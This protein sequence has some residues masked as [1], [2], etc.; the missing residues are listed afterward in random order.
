[1]KQEFIGTPF[2]D[3]N[4]TREIL[5]EAWLTFG[6]KQVCCLLS[7]GSG[8]PAP[9]S[10]TELSRR[11][12]NT[13]TTLRRIIHENEKLATELSHQLRHVSSYLRLNVDRGMENIQN[14]DWQNLGP[15]MDHTYIYLGDPMII[16]SIDILTRCLV[17]RIGTVTLRELSKC[18]LSLGTLERWLTPTKRW[19]SR[20]DHS[21][22]RTDHTYEN[23]RLNY[24]LKGFIPNSINHIRPY[25]L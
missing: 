14:S 10:L 15:I 16:D 23:I 21:Q 5:R 25:L 9:L 2:T 18:V 24:Y 13:Q 4:P 8:R 17:Q 6:D 20:D 11:E 1:M 7:L 12:G 3:H 22:V 19:S